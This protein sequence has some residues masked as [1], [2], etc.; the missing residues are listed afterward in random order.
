M[1]TKY[2]ISSGDRLKIPHHTSPARKDWDKAYKNLLV[3]V[4][5]RGDPTRL[6]PVTIPVD[7]KFLGHVVK[8]YVGGSRNRVPLYTR[9]LAGGDRLPPLVVRRYGDVWHVTDGNARM[10]AAI[11]NGNIK[12]LKAYEVVDPPTAQ[13]PK[14]PKLKK[15]TPDHPG[16]QE[17]H[18]EAFEQQI[19]K[20]PDQ[21]TLT[22][23]RDYTN[24]RTFLALDGKSG[25]G[26]RP[27]PTNPKH[28]EL[29]SVFSLE[30]GHGNHA[31]QHALKNGA[32]YLDAF[33]GYLP[34]W[35]QKH[36]FKTHRREPNY[37]GANLPGVVFMSTTGEDPDLP[38]N[39]NSLTPA[40][41]E[42]I[43]PDMTKSEPKEH[44]VFAG[45]TFGLMSADAPKGKVLIPGGH[46]ALARVLNQM[47]LQAE[48]TV[49][50]YEVPEASYIIHNPTVD[51]MQHLG[52]M[53]GQESVIHSENG[54]HKLI[55]TNGEKTGKYVQNQPEEPIT[56]F[57]TAPE[58]FFT[59]VPGHG[60]FRINFDWNQLHD[61][62]PVAKSEFD[63]SEPIEGEVVDLR[64]DYEKTVTKSD[65]T[66]KLNPRAYYHVTDRQSAHE[67][68]QHGFFGGYG[69]VGYGAY[70]W[71]NPEYAHAW[72]GTGSYNNN[73]SDSV[74]LE[75]KDHAPISAMHGFHPDWEDERDKYE[76]M[77]YVPMDENNDEATWRPSSIK[78]YHDPKAQ[79]TSPKAR[80]KLPKSS[81]K[82]KQPPIK[83]PIR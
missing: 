42:S 49:G 23:P 39:T 21:S 61:L 40:G 78:I 60:H 63:P 31:V 13:P 29:I 82:P 37:Y 47:G 67:I 10:T 45:G 46:E 36:G 15:T 80:P 43:N 74:I 38:A 69:D 6:R 25:Y 66:F 32:T 81:I 12:T 75:I 70:F 71:N 14:P 50:K 17:V 34:G 33:E 1:A 3:E 76:N 55:Y 2:W 65:S 77:S 19:A 8:E 7:E 26:L 72:G 5:G 57:E 30:K 51:Q 52:K 64:T 79:S 48:A 18:P 11:R 20:V 35:Y 22:N 9:M 27:H 54:V 4:F 83:K 68:M 58:D 56:R 16:Y 53:F 28:T 24:V 44:P 62:A 73:L 59:H 41:T